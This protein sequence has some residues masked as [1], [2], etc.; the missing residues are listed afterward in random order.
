MAP[1]IHGEVRWPLP[2]R[3]DGGHL[4]PATPMSFTRP[5]TR[6]TTKAVA[7]GR[8]IYEQSCAGCHPAG[9]QISN[10]GDLYW[11]ATQGHAMPP[12]AGDDGWNVVHYLMVRAQGASGSAPDFDFETLG[13]EQGSLVDDVVTLLVFYDDSPS[14]RARLNQLAQ[15]QTKNRRILA[16]PLQSPAESPLSVTVAPDVV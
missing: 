13:S 1:A 2:Y 12:L 10:Q 6:L 16:I 15:H 9:P 4:V 11:W 7:Q 8:H 5:A 14:S 3:L